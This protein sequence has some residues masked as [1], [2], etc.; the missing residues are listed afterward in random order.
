MGCLWAELAENLALVSILQLMLKSIVQMA[1]EKITETLDWLKR[2]HADGQGDVRMLSFPAREGRY[3]GFP[4]GIDERVV[5]V[6]RDRGVSMPYN[7]QAQAIQEALMGRHVVVATPTASG[8]TL[9]Y[10]TLTLNALLADSSA[11]SLYLF[12]TKALSQ[13]QLAE[14]FELNTALGEP[15]GLYT[16]DGDTPQSMRKSIRKQAHIIL[17]NPYML[18]SGILP[19]HTKWAS[20]FRNLRYVIIDELHYY[21]GVF[22]SHMANIMRRLQRICAFYGS[23]PVFVMS[24]ATISNPGELACRMIG[25]DVVPVLESGAPSG[26]KHLVFVNPPLVNR[27]LGIRR[28]YI[29]LVREISSRLLNL[30]LS[31]ITFANSRLSVEVL[32]KYLKNDCERRVDQVGLVRGYRGGYLPKLRREIEKGLREGSIRAVVS[33]NALELGIDIGSLDAVVLASYPGSIASTWQRIGRAGRRSGASLGILVCSSSPIDQFIASTPAYFTGR[34]PEAGRINPDNLSILVDHM[35]CAAFELPFIRGESFGSEDSIEI[36]SYL[37]DQGVLYYK[38]DRWF[39]TE[40]GYPAD[41]V[42][43][44]RVSSDNFVVVD[45]TGPERVIAEV[46]F[47]SAL[48]T[49]HPKAVYILEGEQ[50]VVEELDFENRKAFVRESNADYY[51][52]AISYTK[53]TVLDC[54][55]ETKRKDYRLSLGDVHVFSQVVGFKKL[56]FFSNE[57]VGAGD[58]QLPQR[59]MHTSSLWMTISEEALDALDIPDEDKIEAVSGLGYL[60][61]YMAAIMLL[62]DVRDLG[63]A[64]EDSVTQLALRT[65]VKAAAVSSGL[66]QDAPVRRFAPNIYLFDNYPNG[67][68]LTEGLYERFDELLANTVDAIKGCSCQSGC[69]SCVGP[70]ARLDSRHKDGALFL[71]RLLSDLMDN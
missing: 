45:C 8:K 54:F 22:G 41:A 11:K 47:S 5:S 64:L 31:V 30:G 50:Y 55:D 52:D 60:M 2:F 33:T 58:L 59:E 69:P 19:H 35:K 68:G 57:N 24:S 13:D 14:L 38:D 42:S 62:C 28:S 25:R 40:E 67:V 53:V 37:Q 39:W 51:T 43:I 65:Y 36:L 48:E 12:P 56:K 44:T 63:V 3:V 6:Y 71:I 7:H 26:E 1:D 17:S 9:I 16:Y 10:N 4:V 66:C 23:D 15:F 34:S 70:S 32:V 21:T 29:S 27:Q 18:H 46:D 20:L 49:L 61:R